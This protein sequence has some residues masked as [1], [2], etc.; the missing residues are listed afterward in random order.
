MEIDVAVGVNFGKFCRKRF[1]VLFGYA[2]A[3]IESYHFV[4]VVFERVYEL[5]CSFAYFGAFGEYAFVVK[6]DYIPLL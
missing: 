4:L 5:Y 2:F 6:P 1:G 3:V